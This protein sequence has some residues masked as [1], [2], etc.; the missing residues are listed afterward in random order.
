MK[1]ICLTIYKKESTVI[2]SFFF[3]SLCKNHFE[4]SLL[5][6]NFA[7]SSLF[8]SLSSI[9]ICTN[10]KIKSEFVI[11]FTTFLPLSERLWYYI[12]LKMK[13]PS[14]FVDVKNNF[15]YFVNSLI[16]KQNCNIIMLVNMRKRKEDKKWK[17]QI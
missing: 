10:S 16:F 9:S 17:I 8:L 6:F 1:R 3:Q 4:F 13:N 14:K 12:K 5:S 7:V 2:L 15:K 11:A